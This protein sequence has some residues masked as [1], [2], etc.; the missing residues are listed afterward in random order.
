M[1]TRVLSLQRGLSTLRRLD[2]ADSTEEPATPTFEQPE[3]KFG[4]RLERRRAELLA[5][6]PGATAQPSLLVP[7]LRG[8]EALDNEVDL[9]RVR[10]GSSGTTEA[11]D[12]SAIDSRP[13]FKLES[14]KLESL[15][16]GPRL[17][18]LRM[19]LASSSSTFATNTWFN[20]HTGSRLTASSS[21][22][23]ST[24]KAFKHCVRMYPYT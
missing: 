20:R 17:S 13:M 9:E 6:D 10:S 24:P 7:L 19:L 22:L 2:L 15:L 1:L 14:C 8:E 3:E 18:R 5:E 11:P 21:Q 4:V 23:L 16:P 12:S